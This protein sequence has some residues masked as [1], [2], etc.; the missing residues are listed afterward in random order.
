MQRQTT[1]SPND[2]GIYSQLSGYYIKHQSGP[3][4]SGIDSHGHKN[5]A[6]GPWR[7]GPVLLPQAME[8]IK[9]GIGGDE[10]PLKVLGPEP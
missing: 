8:M 9:R 10:G 5:M 6:S 1:G 4:L 2:G 3:K 7:G